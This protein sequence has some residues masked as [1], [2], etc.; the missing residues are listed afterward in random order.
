MKYNHRFT[1]ATLVQSHLLHVLEV[2]KHF[3]QS[4]VC[5]R[6]CKTNAC[7]SVNLSTAVLHLFEACIYAHYCLVPYLINREF[8]SVVSAK[9]SSVY[10]KVNSGG[11]SMGENL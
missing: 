7:E 5:V 3:A 8:N 1:C 11:D 4:Q 9:F 6:V 10:N 2:S